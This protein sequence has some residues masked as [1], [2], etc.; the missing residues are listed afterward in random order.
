MAT[1]SS[2]QRLAHEAAERMIREI[3]EGTAPWVRSWEPGQVP[4]RPVNAATGKPYRGY[5]AIVLSGP[6][7][8]RWCT[9]R[10]A[11]SLGAQV[12]RGEHGQV[13]TYWSR[14]TREKVLDEAGHPVRDEA[15]KLR[16][17]TVAR[18]RPVPCRAV[19]FHASQIDGLPPYRTPTPGPETNARV[20][21][22]LEHST[23][24]V[25]H[26][27]RNDPP[28]YRPGTDTIGM[29]PKGAFKDS[30]GYH[31]ILLH[32]FAHA[33]GHE[34]RLNRELVGKR[35]DKEKYA[36]EELRAELASFLLA[37][38]MGTGFHP[39]QHAAYIGSWL[40]ALREDPAEV[41]K[42][43]RDAAR[44]VEYTLEVE[45]RPEVEIL[46]ERERARDAA[47][48][49][50]GEKPHERRYLDVPY[51]ERREAK[52]AGAK[53]DRDAKRW[54]APE[55]LEDLSGL[56]RWKSREQVPKYPGFK[57][58]PILTKEPR[59]R[60]ERDHEAFR[61]RKVLEESAR[62]YLDVPYE[63]RKEAKTAGAKWD[64]KAKRWYVPQDLEDASGL[65]RWKPK[66][67]G[68]DRA[69]SRGF[70]ADRAWT[71]HD[72]STGLSQYVEAPGAAPAS[73]TSPLMALLEVGSLVQLNRDLN[74]IDTATVGVVFDKFAGDPTAKDPGGVGVGIIFPNGK[75][76]VFGA[77][78]AERFLSWNGESASANARNYKFTGSGQ[79]DA[80]YREGVFEGA[81]EQRQVIEHPGGGVSMAEV[82]GRVEAAG[83]E[84]LD[85]PYEE[86]REAKEAGAK[87]DRSAARWYV[88]EG[89][90]DRSGLER[91]ERDG[92]WW[93]LGATRHEYEGSSATPKREVAGREYLDVP[94]EERDAAKEAGAKWDWKARSWYAPT[95]L[96]DRSGLE[97]WKPRNRD[98]AAEFGEV[99]A[100]AGLVLDGPPQFD[101]E[102][103]RVPVEGAA[104]G[105]RDGAYVGHAD[106]PM[107][108][109][110]Q[111]H[112]SGDKG[113]W[114]ASGT[115][116]HSLDTAQIETQRREREATREREQVERAAELER[117]MA[118][119][120]RLD[121]GHQ[122]FVSKG[123]DSASVRADVKGDRGDIVIPIRDVE[124]K[125]QSVQRIGPD[126]QK[127]NAKGARMSGGS[128]LVGKDDGRGPVY[129]AS[130]F[131]TAA[132]IHQ[133]TGAP[134][135]AAMSDANMRTIAE[136]LANR[137]GNRPMVIC[138]DDDHLA[139]DGKGR[140][141]NSGEL[142]AR[143]AAEATGAA[144]V[145]PQFGAKRGAKD[146]DFADLLKTEGP[147]AVS[148]QVREGAC[149]AVEL[150]RQR[151][152]EADGP[153][154]DVEHSPAMSR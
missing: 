117:E 124:G 60:S 151:A 39:G 125:I 127:H 133:A 92:A 84:Y 123:I 85:V 48:A 43:G 73:E 52:A 75:Y 91:W 18:D 35:A 71:V 58:R 42:A 53:W 87:W 99:L 116:G 145:M 121:A 8:P 20:A 3:E 102:L 12:R 101:G 150:R 55:D 90:E 80:D 23:V 137:N 110:Y 100:N 129:V 49:R 29:P 37:Q 78:Q 19:V 142:A 5:N 83:R 103:H 34:S 146:T 122:Y 65:D 32:E 66:D 57:L 152:R 9:Y 86:R 44:I 131:A 24:N 93:A 149:K 38:E 154:Q 107:S 141:R 106:A 46:R 147:A 120:G 64:P 30:E 27:A 132:A 130:G 128:V 144:V 13:I 97:R 112:R 113:T 148:R 105:K 134:V 108:G 95:D 82:P 111:N 14:E 74:G 28:H 15:G 67:R 89:L 139:K 40:K 79:L 45:K 115:R 104:P 25:V 6:E 2:Y 16:Y 81:F 41:F 140:P 47:R 77:G 10:Q 36:R 88:P 94:Y 54:Y 135:W 26:D 22:V 62:L 126:G 17:R 21:K 138:G 136:G 118:S 1:M 72:P 31:E 7:D 56:D 109:W 4:G 69:E 61:K 153:A 96:E 70:R 63:E 114:R 76:G 98:P 51:E 11:E 33:T 50:K 119:M 143:A 59:A 68:P